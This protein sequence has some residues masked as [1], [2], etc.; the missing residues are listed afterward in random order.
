MKYNDLKQHAEM[1][2]MAADEMAHNFTDFIEK[3]KEIAIFQSNCDFNLSFIYSIA[4][5]VVLHIESI[6]FLNKNRTNL[7][8][9]LSVKELLRFD[10]LINHY[11]PG[12]FEEFKKLLKT[13]KNET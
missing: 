10:F 2:Q 8:R 6:E 13:N 12:N 11:K 3:N 5:E 4:P 9:K 1:C 7:K